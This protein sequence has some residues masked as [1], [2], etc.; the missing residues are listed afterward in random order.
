MRQF[1]LATQATFYA[2][3]GQ[4]GDHQLCAALRDETNALAD[5]IER[6]LNTHAPLPHHHILLL[7]PDQLRLFAKSLP[8]PVR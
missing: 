8:R 7:D 2:A 6:S 3:R 4:A 5:E 1:E